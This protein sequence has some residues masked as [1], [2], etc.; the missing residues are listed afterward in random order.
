MEV[1]EDA[2]KDYSDYAKL[3]FDLQVLALRTDQTRIITFMMGKESSNRSYREVGV[4]A[5]APWP[6]P[7]PGRQRKDR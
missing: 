7:P 4:K 5:R 1:P 3:M 2:P 6:E